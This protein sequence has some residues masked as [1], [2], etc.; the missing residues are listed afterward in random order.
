MGYFSQWQQPLG[1]YV[2]VKLLDLIK[3]AAK[4]HDRSIAEE[5]LKVGAA[6][7]TAVC[8]SLRGSKVFMLELVALQRHIHLGRGGSVHVYPMKA[9]INLSNTL[10]VIITLLGEFKGELGYKYHIMSLVNTTVSGIELRW[11]I[12]KL[13][14]VREEEGC[15]T[16]PALRHED[17]L[18]ALMWEYN[19]ILITS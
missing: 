16:G 17:G 18:I 14:E 3:E 15:I 19:K 7:A 6:V 5:F 11:W 2:I 4:E 10:H 12:E 9:G 8:T 1:I 13:I